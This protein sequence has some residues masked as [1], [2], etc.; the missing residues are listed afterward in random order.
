MSSSLG[1]CR[2]LCAL[3]PYLPGQRAIVEP[4]PSVLLFLTRLV[5]E[6]KTGYMETLLTPLVAAAKDDVGELK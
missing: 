1:R 3:E 2:E 6:K 4:R 5:H